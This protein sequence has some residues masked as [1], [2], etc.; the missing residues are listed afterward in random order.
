MAGLAEAGP[1]MLVSSPF[2]DLAGQSTHRLF[3]WT[4]HAQRIQVIPALI[5][6]AVACGVPAIALAQS[7]EVD[8]TEFVLTTADGRV[9]RSRDLVGAT[10]KVR[11]E[12]RDIDVIITSVEE[13]SHSVG[14]RVFLHH[15]LTKDDSGKVS[16]LCN[17][18]TTGQS[19]GFPV[20]DGRG[21]FD[22]TCTSGVVGKCVRWGYRPWEEKPGKPMRALHQACTYMARADYGGDGRPTTR[23]GT[24]ID[25]YD[26][27]GIQTS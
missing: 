18:D 26:R 20:P 8:G 17:P 4:T 27:F 7:L 23:E 22:L 16:E 12:G 3:G 9:L 11:S 6:S 24:L 5:L 25:V 14:G 19:L 13:D 2:V 15:F 1:A 21:G 10:L